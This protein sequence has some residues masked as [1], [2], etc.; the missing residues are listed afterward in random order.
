MDWLNGA[1]ELGLLYAFMALGV[2]ITFRILDF[3]DLTVDGSFTTGGAIAAV[4][5]TNGVHPL[6]ATLA[7][8]AGGMLAGACTGLLHTKGRINGLLSGILMMIALYSINLRIMGKPNV[9]M[10]GENIVFASID[11]LIIMPFV[12]III[13]VLLDLFLR[14]D[15]GLALRATG[16]NAK[17]IRSFGV[18]TDNTI[19]LGI[20]LSNGL[21][22]LSGALVSQVSGFADAS[23]GIG[24]IVIGLAS[25]I[26]GEAIF[27]AKSVF[28][29]TLAVVLGSIVYRI[30]V[31]LALR[32]NLDAS[33]LKL[34]TAII[35]II[36]LVFPSIQRVFKEKST[37]R[38]RT[39]ELV[40]ANAKTDAVASKRGG[41]VNAGA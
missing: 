31:A 30:V 1:V 21:V 40:A 33:D 15:L 35:V 11:P 37:A 34:I 26:I 9:S 3:P 39:A 24:M 19:I 23:A 29:A 6:L 17:M 27:G 36:A 28:R 18:N 16:D 13:K 14:T 12:V 22:A 7:A 4:L 25:V 2:Y 8:G 20:S 32:V 10:M 38:K 5:I 41:G